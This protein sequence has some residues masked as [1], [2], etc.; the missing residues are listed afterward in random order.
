[1]TIAIVGQKKS[2]V[3][4]QFPNNSPNDLNQM[5]SVPSLNQLFNE[6]MIRIN[7]F[8]VQ[9]VKNAFYVSMYCMWMPGHNR[10]MPTN[11]QNYTRLYECPGRAGWN[12]Y[13]NPYGARPNQTSQEWIIKKILG[14]SLIVS[15]GVCNTNIIMHT[16]SCQRGTLL[17]QGERRVH[18]NIAVSVEFPVT[19]SDTALFK[20]LLVA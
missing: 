6:P 3:C 16:D 5:N 2:G 8:Q 13:S 17:N 4:I 20:W 19:G 9:P 18:P 7:K 11:K 1:M 15:Q 14:R 10:G 12:K